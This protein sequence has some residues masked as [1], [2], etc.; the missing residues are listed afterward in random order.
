MV[1]VAAAE[2]IVNVVPVP[3]KTVLLA[4]AESSTLKVVAVEKLNKTE[5]TVDEIG[6]EL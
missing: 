5:L 2:L 6:V 4:K 3:E 1:L